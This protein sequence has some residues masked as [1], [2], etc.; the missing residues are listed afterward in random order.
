V[1]EL[2]P[3]RRTGRN[4]FDT[5][6]AVRELSENATLRRAPT[7]LH[8]EPWKPADR[9]LKPRPGFKPE[10]RPWEGKET[11]AQRERRAAVNLRVA[12]LTD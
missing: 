8:A 4:Y 7:A 10:P 9:P 11:E 5:L 12:L 1:K 6:V 2:I 3:A